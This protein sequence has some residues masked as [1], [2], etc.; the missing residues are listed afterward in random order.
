[1]SLV[2]WRGTQ[3]PARG[4]ADL[5]GELFKL[6]EHTDRLSKSAEIL[7]FKISRTVEQIGRACKATE[8]ENDAGLGAGSGGRRCRVEE[9]GKAEP[10]LVVVSRNSRINH[11]QDRKNL[12]A[13]S[14][15]QKI[16]KHSKRR[17]C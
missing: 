15:R 12:L 16:S 10:L 5:D 8:V 3:A 17:L 1:M 6:T 11:L 9:P 13:K 4:R 7:D 2:A 14:A